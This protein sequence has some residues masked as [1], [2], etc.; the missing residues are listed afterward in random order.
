MKKLLISLV[1][2]SLAWSCTWYSDKDMNENPQRATVEYMQNKL[3]SV[4]R[5][6]EIADFFDRYQKI[7][8]DRDASIVL[9]EWYFGG[10]FRQEDLVYEG[11]NGGLWGRIAPT[12]DPGMYIVNPYNYEQ[13]V[14]YHVEITA[15][16]KFLISTTPET[17]D[18][19]P[20]I[21]D[22]TMELECTASLSGNDMIIEAMDLTYVEDSGKMKTK[23]LI[24]STDDPAR[25]HLCKKGSREDMPFAG[26]L[27]YDVENE[28]IDDEFSVRYSETKKYEIL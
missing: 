16:R 3:N 27:S 4:F 18:I 6:I 13:D 2:A 15:D 14:I 24:K 8:E 9:G 21:N 19:G 25:M 7:R 17:K 26:T 28:M 22:F 10:A 23:V 1:I 20:W 11:Y 12:S 5:T